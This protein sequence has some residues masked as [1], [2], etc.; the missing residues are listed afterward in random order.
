MAKKIKLRESSNKTCINMVKSCA[1]YGCTNRF[2][3]DNTIS[4]H[5]FP[6]SNPELCK[7]WVIATKRKN[8]LPTKYS[9]I[10]SEHFLST[11]YANSDCHKP[12]LKEEAVPS[13][14]N[15]P[16][17]LHHR[18]KKA[19]KMP[20]NRSIKEFNCPQVTS[21]LENSP[22]DQ[23]ISTS[24]ITTEPSTST[25]VKL[26]RKV[27]TLQQKVRRKEKK[28]E[29]LNEMVKILSDKNYIS[30][31]IGQILDENFSG[32]T[33]EIIQSEISNNTFPLVEDTLMN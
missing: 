12:H 8:F 7:R 14:F 13:I 5:K 6:L 17:N 21:Y 26:R 22:S 31:E 1:A 9:F 20:S 28:I 25:E 32:L 15:F 29:N 33:K 27:K 19:R 4:F 23:V 2:S 16:E 30:F 3:K 18:P 24:P 11:D 10:C